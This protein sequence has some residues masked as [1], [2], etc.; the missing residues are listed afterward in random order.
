M[1]RSEKGMTLIELVM[2]IIIIGI[3]SGVAMKSMDSAIETGRIESTR[4][5]MQ[6]LAD[7]IV[8]NPDLLNN[9]NRIDFGYVGD[10]GSLPANLD[11]LVSAP[12][13]YTTWNGPY[14][15][16]NFVESSDDYK[17]DA[18]GVDY[19]YSAGLTITSTGSGSNITKRLASDAAD[20]TSNSIRGVV[21]DA[22][23]IPPGTHYSEVEISIDYPDG[24]GSTTGTTVNP[25]AGG[26]YALT[27]LPIGNH[28]VTAVYTTT[29]DTVISYVTVP[30]RSDVVNNIRFGYS[31]WAES[32]GSSGSG[33]E[34]V[35]GSA[36]TTGGGSDVEFDITNNTGSSITIDWLKA[37]YTHSPDAYYERVRWNNAT[38]ANRTNPRYGSGDT[39][40]FSTGKSIGDGA[41]VTIKMQN[42]N[43]SQSGG[44]SNADMSGT[45]FTV[46]FSDGSSITFSI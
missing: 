33:V 18:W 2:V 7:A 17:K 34:Y 10:V 35:S 28:T 25:A 27:G 39:A 21:L 13:G 15:S 44:G 11:A 14:I 9:G 37:E 38:V 16:N 23:S 22:G 3:I 43:T 29:N 41:T 30:P 1:I 5:E 40:G 8:G 45:T 26:N 36:T 32:G 6:A 19:Q 20:L 24:A 4:K 42:F 12:G 31:L 46:T